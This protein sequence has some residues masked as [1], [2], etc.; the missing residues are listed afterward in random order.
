MQYKGYTGKLTVDA[1]AGVIFGT[2]ANLRAVVTF[3]GESVKE[4]E[5]AFRDSVDDYLDFCREKGLEPEK[6]YSGKFLVRTAPELHRALAAEAARQGISL[7]EFVG[8]ALSR[9]ATPVG[10]SRHASR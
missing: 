5:Q 9:I 4:A 10:P 6:P 8:E 7:N 2:V 1:E 3:Q